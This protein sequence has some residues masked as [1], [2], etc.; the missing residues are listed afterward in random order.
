MVIP[1]LCFN[2]LPEYVTSSEEDEESGMHEIQQSHQA[3]QDANYQE[4][5]KYIDNYYKTHPIPTAPVDQSA[6]HSSRVIS[7]DRAQI[8]QAQ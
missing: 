5:M 7:D 6:G 2:G 3:Q 4:S 1:D 8:G